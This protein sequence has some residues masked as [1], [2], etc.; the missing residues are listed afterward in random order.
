MMQMPAFQ[1]LRSRLNFY[2]VSTPTN[3]MG[4][5]LAQTAGGNAGISRVQ[6]SS[7]SNGD[8]MD[9]QNAWG[10]SW[11][12][13][14]APAYPVDLI[15]TSQDGSQVRCWPRAR[16]LALRDS[17]VLSLTMRE[18]ILDSCGAGQASCICVFHCLCS[19]T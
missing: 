8:W 13:S 5:F 7:V 18:L 2:T 3:A 9:M 17:R 16:P 10:A 19:S 14:N 6:V 11:Q 12:I 4:L 15:I 1:R